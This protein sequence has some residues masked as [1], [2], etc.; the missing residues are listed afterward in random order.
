MPEQTAVRNP[1]PASIRTSLIGNVNPDGRPIIAGS[2]DSDN[3]VLAMQMGSRSSPSCCATSMSCSAS[4]SNDTAEAPYICVAMVWT[5]FLIGQATSYKCLNA[6]GSSVA[7]TT[8]FANSSA[9]L[10]PSV[11]WVETAASTAPTSRDCSRTHSSSATGSSMNA[12]TA[13][14][15]GTPWA[16]TFAMC[17]SKFAKPFTNAS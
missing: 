7:L 2:C 6:D 17:C 8:A 14:T 3:G 13:T 11:Q 16:L 1:A 5:F 12:L 10:P 9:P 4:A 15:T